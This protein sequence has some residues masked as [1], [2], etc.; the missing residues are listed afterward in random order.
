MN[1]SLFI[2]L[3]SLGV[4][5]IASGN[6]LTTKN[7]ILGLSFIFLGSGI[8]GLGLSGIKEN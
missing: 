3:I 8:L 5:I 7:T 4:N 2:F 6:F 1:K